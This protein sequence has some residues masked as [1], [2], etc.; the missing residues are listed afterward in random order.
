[1]NTYVIVVD[2]TRTLLICFFLSIGSLHAQQQPADWV[3]PFIGTDG[4]GHTF[5]GATTPFGMVQ[6][7]PDTRT[8][9]WEN[10]SGYHSSNNTI[11]GFSHLHLSGTG[12]ADYGDIMFMPTIGK[13]I[14]PGDESS[15]MNGYRS[16]FKKESEMAKPGYY[17]VTLDDH[18]IK[19]ELTATTRTGIQR[20]T[21]PESDIAYVILDLNHG[22]EDK[23]AE[24]FIRIV[25]NKTVQGYRRSKGWAKDQIVFFHSEFSVPFIE[26]EMFDSKTLSAIADNRAIQ[27]GS[28]AAFRFKTKKGQ[29]ITL[30]TGVSTVS[31]E[32]AK[33]NLTT[34][35][36][37]WDFEGFRKNAFNNWN[38]ELSRIKVEGDN[39]NEKII[40]YT[41]LYHCMIHPSIMSDVD[42]RYRGMDDKIHRMDRGNM[43]TVFSLWDTFR[44][45]H[46]L[47]TI[48]DPIR[49]QEFVRALLRKYNES[50][51]LPVWE[52]ASNETGCMIGY[53]SVPV[54]VDTYMKGL[55]D[56]DTTLAL[57][58][59]VKSAM[60]DHLGLKH[61]KALGYIPADKENESVSK[62][63]E[64]AYDD[65]C[66]AQMAK[67]MGKKNESELFGKRARYY[68]NV[69]DKSSGFVRGKK[70][71]NWVAPFDPYEVSGIYTEANAWQYNFFMPHDIPG[72]INLNNGLPNFTTRLDTLFSANTKLTGRSQPD[73]SGMIGQYAHGNEPSHHMAY[74]YNYTDKPYRTAQLTRKIMSEMYGTGRDGLSGNEDCGQMSAWYVLSAL[75]IYP[76]SPGNNLYEIGSPIFKKAVINNGSGGVTTFLAN[77]SD[78][79]NI[80]IESILINGKEVESPIQ[81]S[82]L[83]GGST[84]NFQMT[85]VSVKN[86][87]SLIPLNSDTI[88]SVMMPFVSSCEK[89]FFDSCKVSMSCHTEG[90]EIRFTR[91]GTEPH[92]GSEV[93]REP[94]SI[95]ETTKIHLKAFKKG[96]HPSSTE[97]VQFLKLPYKKL[98]TYKNEYSHNYTGGGK[99]GLVDGINGEPNAFGSWQ[100]F[101]G[102]DFEAAIDLGEAREF[103]KLSATFLQ[104]YPSW[105]WLPATVYF[106]VSSDG[107]SYSE[108]HR[109]TNTVSLDKDGSFVEAFTYSGPKQKA[110]FVKVV[111]TNMGNCPEWHPGSGN[112]TWI[113]IDEITVE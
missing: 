106:Y 27:G 15:P 41:S 101:Y 110:R 52:L 87:K 42:G 63:L 14:R 17:A 103:S 9:G 81:H 61:Y 3:D 111:G 71:G 48:I 54:I 65:W 10:C 29:Q 21:F 36:A 82:V 107:V 84:I 12:A 49:A 11:I 100:G 50:G 74:L 2:F 104:Q 24:T 70:N 67:N 38:T 23:A 22:I 79:A 35:A 53:H 33:L 89:S 64:Y 34:E 1:M 96:F 69:F 6:L 98:V 91:D 113:F 77:A 109:Q 16:S 62:T 97:H 39:K 66:I 18:G 43:Y 55:R 72:M 25:G 83:A 47:M 90:A 26:N 7:S 59:C 5:P 76:V 78:T 99:N 73:I 86:M 95:K 46:P 8:T 30:K 58:A 88:Q 85:S 93:Y 31:A 56:F 13:Q 37:S 94:I 28:V 60:M 57:E 105:I 75:G 108:I 68:L 80:H 45:L 92:E 19:V 40:F 32:N 4:F 112:P 51:T 102:K 44:A 20:Y